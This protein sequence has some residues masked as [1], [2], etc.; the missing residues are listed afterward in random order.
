MIMLRFSHL[1]MVLFLVPA[2]GTQASAVAPNKHQNSGPSGLAI[3]RFVSLAS[4]TVH[5]RAGPGVRYPIT[6][7]YK[8]RGTPFMVMAEHEY[9]RKVRDGEGTEGWMHR[10]L[11]SNRRMGVLRGGVADLYALPNSN[12]RVTLRAEPGVIGK[13]LECKKSWCRMTL[14]NIKAWIPRTAIFGTLDT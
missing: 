11:L 5:M 13:L 14:G 1:F 4:D 10:S 7:I 12:S 3:P 6:W 2:I 9:W 8:R